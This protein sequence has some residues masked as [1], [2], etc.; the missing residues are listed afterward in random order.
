MAKGNKL[1]FGL[2]VCL[3]LGHINILSQK[4]LPIA[5]D[6]QLCDQNTVNIYWTRARPDSF[7]YVLQKSGDE[8][9]WETIANNIN[10]RPLPFYDYIDLEGTRDISFYRIAQREHGKVLAVSDVKSVKVN[11]A[12]KLHVWPTPANNILHVQSPFVNGNIDIIDCDGRF[13]RKITIIDSITSVPLQ[14][15]PGGMYFIHLRH[16]KDVLVKRFIKQGS[17]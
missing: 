15:L 10:S 9:N 3:F 16:G 5:F 12:N 11:K 17:Y 7:D 13:I 8:K 1:S 6:V 2:L 4:Q 14:A